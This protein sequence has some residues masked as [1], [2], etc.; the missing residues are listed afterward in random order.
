ML[1]RAAVGPRLL[2]WL[3]VVAVAVAVLLLWA[4][5][6]GAQSP[7]NSEAVLPADQQGWRSDCEALWEFYS[8]LDDVGVLDDAGNEGAWGSGTRFV[9]WQGVGTGPAGVVRLDLSRAGLSG[10]LSPALGRLKPSGASEPSY[11]F[12]VR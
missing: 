8:G 6:A 10:P 7:C 9:D 5:P 3:G 1:T 4:A 11:Q 2:W 12:S